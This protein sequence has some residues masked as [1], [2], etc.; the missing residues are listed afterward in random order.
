MRFSDADVYRAGVAR[1]G[2]RAPLMPVT[3]HVFARADV[4][5]FM[6][7]GAE[8][9][10]LTRKPTAAHYALRRNAGGFWAR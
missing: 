1:P 3:Q 5:S 2:D 4:Y 9:L 8:V 7:F 6:E 10:T